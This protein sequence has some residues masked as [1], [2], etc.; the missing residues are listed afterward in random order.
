MSKCAF[1]LEPSLQLFEAGAELADVVELDLFDDESDRSVLRPVVDPAAKDEGLAV[2]G[3][4][5]D[6]PLVIGVDERVDQALAVTN[7]EA[8]VAFGACFHPT[9]L[10][11]YHQRGERTQLEP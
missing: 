5:R 8:V 10:T 11:I 9:D 2:L 3:Q 7:G 1:R 6:P 4:G